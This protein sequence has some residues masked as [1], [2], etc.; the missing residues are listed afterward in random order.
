[1]SDDDDGVDVD[2]GLRGS[3]QSRSVGGIHGHSN[4]V[5]QA[6]AGASVNIQ[7]HVRK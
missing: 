1:M 5:I 3:D 6:G 4:M 7:R 2:T